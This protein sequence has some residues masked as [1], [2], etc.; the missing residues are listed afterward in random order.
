MSISLTFS[1]GGKPCCN[2]KV[3]KNVVSCKFNHTALVID[4]DIFG[5]LTTGNS[6]DT[7]IACKCTTIDGS[8]C[9][10]KPWWKFWVKN[11]TKNCTCSKQV[12]TTDAASEG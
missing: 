5:Q 1:G 12:V 10:K 7:P 3:G 11:S 2:K 8:Q 4:K 6:E 9:A